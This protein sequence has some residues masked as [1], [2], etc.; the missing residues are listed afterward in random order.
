MSVAEFFE[1]LSFP[2][3][4]FQVEAAESIASG[5]SVVVTA[6]TGSGKTLVAEVAVHLALEKGRRAFYTTPIKAL[7]NQKFNELTAWHGPDR[8]G[9]LTGDNVVNGDA[10]VVVM[11][12]EVLRNMIY[13]DKSTLSQVGVVILDE[14]HYLQ[15]RFRGAVWE[16][17]IIHAPRHLQMVALSATIANAAE[18][19]DWVAARRG[20]TDLVTTTDR[21][22]PL[23]PHYMIKD[24]HSHEISLLPT[25]ATRD[26]RTRPNPRIERMLSLERGR[27]RRYT[28]P[29]RTE[30]VLDLAERAMLPAIY[31]IFSRAGCDAAALAVYEYGVRLTDPEEREEI[32]RVA[33]A[34]T[35]HLSDA[36]LSVLGYDRWLA[37]LEMGVAAHHAG[38][39][40]AFKETVEDLFAAGLLGVVFATETLAL[41]INMPARTVVLESLSKFDGESHELLQ[42]GDYTQLTGRA[43][44]RGIDDV[45]YGVV[46][47]SSYVPF[48]NVTEIAAAGS[49]PLT[50]SFRPTYNMAANLVANY[51]ESRAVEL[52]EASFAQYQQVADAG[53]AVERLA[54]L[55]RRLAEEERQAECERGSVA[56]Y[57]DTV[58][59]RPGKRAGGELAG[60]LR[61]G[62]V[63]DVPGGARQGRYAVLKRLA[64]DEGS[65]LLVLGTSGRVSTIGVRDVV[66]G[67]ERSG[68][69]DLPTPFRPRDRAFRQNALRALRKVSSPERRRGGTPAAATPRHPVED[70][71]DLQEHVDWLRKARRTRRRIDQLNQALRRQGVGLVAQFDAIRAI[72]EEWGYLGGWQLTPRG[73]RL[74]FIY[75]ELDLLLTEAT[76]RGLL[77]ALDACELAAFASTFV[78]EPR[79]EESG[80]PAW[81]TAELADRWEKLE[82][83]WEELS[84]LE[85]S[86]GLP[87]TRH[88]DHGV[89]RAVYQ[90]ASGVEFEDLDDRAMAPGD[91][92][93]VSRQLVDLVRQIRQA[94]PEIADVAR[95]ALDRIDRGVVAAQGVA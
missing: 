40:P 62:D 4:K 83:L 95:D 37:S 20:P 47:H 19:A 11:T 44:R 85:Q 92:V 80:V 79:R 57:F 90:W 34:R 65:R 84:G 60:A 6:P 41:G 93:R 73:S 21:P 76:E 31:F 9:L 51:E 75:N 30:V 63:I 25:F 49:H 16:E 43:G 15:D 50:S 56:E 74:R 48:R 2:P 66:E 67:T 81:P 46:L 36:D 23:E 89:V 53:E 72:L 39:V 86:R 69:I 29:R 17:V 33:E 59:G 13:T 1:A 14:V 54:E 26:G 42:P 28:A 3:D 78:Y 82:G 35:D 68:R 61:P 12:T 58:E 45:G 7:S 55:E 38:M 10:D 87:P 18:F 70:C 27:S 8:V 64:R 94:A 22:V 52:L 5:R 77:W 24:R 32:R 71:P 88:P 91:F